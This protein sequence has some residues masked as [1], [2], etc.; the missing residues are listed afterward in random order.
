MRDERMRVG[1][2]H[3][4]GSAR[5]DLIEAVL[6]VP[7]DDERARFS[8]TALLIGE[9]YRVTEVHD[10]DAAAASIATHDAALV[11]VPCS[12]RR[13]A[14]VTFHDTLRRLQ[15]FGVPVVL[16]GEGWEAR[17]RD[18]RCGPSLETEAVAPARVP[19]DA[20]CGATT[21]VTGR[22]GGLVPA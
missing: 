10:I 7:P 13:R 5:A 3:E 12:Q 9:G 6:L 15:A 16:L 17:L 22:A 4:P 11:F 20:R 2:T 8:Y 18:S 1:E 19:I 14:L 21:A